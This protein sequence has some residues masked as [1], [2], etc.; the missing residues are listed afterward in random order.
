MEHHSS[1]PGTIYLCL[2]ES[3]SKNSDI[4]KRIKLVQKHFQRN[5]YIRHDGIVHG[6]PTH[7]KRDLA[8]GFACEKWPLQTKDFMVRCRKF[9]WP[10]KNTL[11]NMVSSG[12]FFAP[13]GSR[14]SRHDNDPNSDIEWRL[15]FVQA[16]QILVRA[17]N[18]C[19]FLCY[20][21]V[22]MFLCDVLNKNATEEEKLLCSY[23]IK[24]AMFWCIQTDPGYEWSKENFFECFWKCYKLLL[25][26]VYAGYCPN[27]FIPQNNL[28]VC[29]I[30]GADQEKLFT[31]MYNLYCSGK[32]CLS[33]I[34][35][36]QAALWFGAK[37]KLTKS[38]INQVHVTDRLISDAIDDINNLQ[39]ENIPCVWRALY[40]YKIFPIDYSNIEQILITM[41]VFNV[42]HDIALSRQGICQCKTKCNIN[43]QFYTKHK[44]I[45]N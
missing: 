20:V 38:K 23:N 26:W 1:I 42:Y 28:F 27:F 2:K 25:S 6:V 19:Q 32:Q 14:Q 37:P 30:L 41:H 36:L 44:K 45:R 4:L 15:S 18:H 5:R 12:C 16:E 39:C 3:F 22:K 29:K 10:A 7:F 34:T 33:T 17:M 9:G 21:L 40:L 11:K 24:T 31:E 43:K 13:V 35:P 8:V